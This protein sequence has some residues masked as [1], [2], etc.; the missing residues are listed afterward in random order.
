MVIYH[1]AHKP[2]F[3]FYHGSIGDVF[4]CFIVKSLGVTS[5]E[6]HIDNRA[7]SV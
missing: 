5:F 1:M 7:I 6:N 2:D 3:F 4:L